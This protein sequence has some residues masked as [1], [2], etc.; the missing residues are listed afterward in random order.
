M[1]SQHDIIHISMKAK[2]MNQKCPLHSELLTM[3]CSTSKAMLCMRCFS[4]ASLETRLHC[5][6]LDL[7]Y[8]QGKKKL[9]RALKVNKEMSN[10][11]M[12]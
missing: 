3:F 12:S 9:K 7:A 2:A 11:S 1:F 6:D 4:E 10:Y 8:D 5:L